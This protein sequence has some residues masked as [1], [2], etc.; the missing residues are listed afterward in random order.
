M[1]TLSCTG[2]ESEAL[3]PFA[4]LH[5]LLQP[6]VDRIDRLA[7]RQ[8]DALLAAFGMADAAAADIFLTALAGLDLLSE[9][10]SETPALVIVENADALDRSTADVLAFV[11][12]RLEY[13][14][15][16]LIAATRE[17]YDTPLLHAGLQVLHL[18]PLD[19][20][21]AAALLDDSAP[22]IPTAVRQRVLDEAG[23]NPLAS[24]GTT[25]GDAPRHG[26]LLRRGSSGRSRN[27]WTTF[28]RQ[29][30]HCCWSRRSMTA[31]R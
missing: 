20:S 16:V 12:R 8:R 2:V 26:F 15:I 5:Q 24:Q 10:A 31:P 29:R 7:E 11:A 14:P 23:G 4:G 1:R 18:E 19:Q 21:A 22:G 9:A 6:I 17:G 25:A 3:L 30:A 13:E 27:G 28:L